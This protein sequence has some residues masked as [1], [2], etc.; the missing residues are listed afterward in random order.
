MMAV[1]LLQGGRLGGADG[2]RIMYSDP[3]HN[4]PTNK[5]R[6]HNVGP[7]SMF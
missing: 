2:L 7:D 3:Y 6:V 4:E 1:A 5:L